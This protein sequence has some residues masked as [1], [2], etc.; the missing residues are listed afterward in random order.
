[1]IKR[2]FLEVKDAIIGIRR[3]QYAELKKFSRNIRDKTILELGSGK[4]VSGKHKYSAK[5]YFHD[6]NRFVMTDINKE[7]GHKIFDITKDSEK[8]KYDIILCLNVLEHLMDYEKAVENLRSSLKKGGE[9]FVAVPFLYPLHDEPCDFLR[10][11][12][13]AL[14]KMFSKFSNVKIRHYGLRK[15]PFSYVIV[16]RK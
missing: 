5:K 12:E 6:S 13:H 7:F 11:T 4:K 15:L 3:F 10:Y 8:N 16:A 2:L 1:M 14:K 9:V